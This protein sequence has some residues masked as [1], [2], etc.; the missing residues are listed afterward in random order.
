MGQKVNPIAFRT[1]VTR[2]WCSRWYASKQDFAELLLEDR[3]LRDFIMNHPN[4]DYVWHIGEESLEEF[5]INKARALNL[6]FAFA[7]SATAGL[8]SSRITNING[9]SQVFYG[10]V[11]CYH[12]EIK[13]DLLRVKESTIE[14]HDVV[15]E[16]VAQ[17]MAAGLAQL[18]PVEV[19]IAIT[20]Y[21]GPHPKEDEIPIGTV[22]IGVHSPLGTS[23][24]KYQFRGDRL[25][26]KDYFAQ[27]ALFQLLE[28]LEKLSPA[29]PRT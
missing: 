26:L 5:I 11:I 8:C 12:S 24:Q 13:M 23:A 28:T 29:L 16:E 18:Y 9:S 17:E 21:A 15:S 25:R 10:S 22:C 1:G 4:K 14:Q 27:T 19:A 2:G 7:E 20:G 3:K 6:H